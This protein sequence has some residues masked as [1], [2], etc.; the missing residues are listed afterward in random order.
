MKNFIT[1]FSLLKGGLFVLLLLTSCSAITDGINIDSSDKIVLG[2]V[3]IKE[4]NCMPGPN[5]P[6]CKSMGKKVIVHFTKP[7]KNYNKSYLISK[8][9][10]D[11]NGNFSSKLSPGTY[12]VFIEYKNEMHCT[13]TICEPTCICSPIEIFNSKNE[14]LTITLDLATY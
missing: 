10:S 6:P 4:G 11:T 5:S 1:S 7:S 12:S 13:Y 14:A 8:I 2:R 9:E 3:L